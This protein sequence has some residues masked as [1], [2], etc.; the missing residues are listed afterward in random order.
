LQV[1][2]WGL[3]TA[4][5][6]AQLLAAVDGH[7]SPAALVVRFEPFLVQAVDFAIGEGLVKRRGGNKLELTQAG[8]LL[9]EE[10]ESNESAFQPEKAFMGLL[11]TKVSEDLINRM[12]GWRIQA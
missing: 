2:S 8:A 12:F 3:R 9:A 10:L 4:E 11:R 1:L 7:L 5:A 6:R